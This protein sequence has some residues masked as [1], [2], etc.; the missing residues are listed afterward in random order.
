MKLK[1]NQ[2]IGNPLGRRLPIDDHPMPERQ[3]S[4]A[5]LLVRLRVLLESKVQAAFRA[6]KRHHLRPLVRYWIR[7]LPVAS[8]RGELLASTRSR[9]R[10]RP[11]I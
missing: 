3:I 11:K 4:L 6:R 7:T 8:T 1:L 9:Y 2:L 10:I 5:P